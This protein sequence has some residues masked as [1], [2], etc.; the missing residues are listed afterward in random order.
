[1]MAYE[2]DVFLSYRRSNDWPRFVQ[3]Q[4]LPKLKHWL[5]TV[6]GDAAKI[7]VDVNEIETGDDWPYALA[8]GL[9]HSKIMVCLWSAEYFRSKWCALELTH[10]LARRKSLVTRSGQL[11]PLILAALIHDSNNLTR[12][13][14]RIQKFPMQDYSNPWIAD[15]SLTEERLSVE[16]EKLARHAG[17]ALM[18]V[19]EYDDSWPSL[20]TAEFMHLFNGEADQDLPPSLGLVDS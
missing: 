1:M 5:D 9:A 12:E 11:P 3:R 20:A 19:P 15:G 10:M 4:F 16:I 13:L 6:L 17:N 18:H 2:W 8:H 14:S 7:F